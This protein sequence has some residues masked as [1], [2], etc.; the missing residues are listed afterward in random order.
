MTQDVR[1]AGRRGEVPEVV[2]QVIS[3]LASLDGVPAGAR[4]VDGALEWEGRGHTTRVVIEAVQ[5]PAESRLAD[6]R[7]V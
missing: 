3:A 5:V 4:W 7:V 1:P 6:A 2:D